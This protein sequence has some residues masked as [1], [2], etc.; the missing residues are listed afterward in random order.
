M[1]AAE[2][3]WEVMEVILS[4]PGSRWKLQIQYLDIIIII[5]SRMSSIVGE[6]ERASRCLSCL[7]ASR[8]P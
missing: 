2:M 8:S 6:R 5:T 4:G 3:S 1:C 7:Q